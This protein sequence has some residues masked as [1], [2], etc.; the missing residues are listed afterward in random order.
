MVLY[1][2]QYRDVFPRQFMFL[3]MILQTDRSYSTQTWRQVGHLLSSPHPTLR[4]ALELVKLEVTS[5]V[6]REVDE[7]QVT[8]LTVHDRGF[9]PVLKEKLPTPSKIALISV[10]RSAYFVKVIH[11]LPV[12]DLCLIFIFALTPVQRS[13]RCWCE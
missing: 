1:L 4:M 10:A 11:R 3:D 2:A 6:N 12:D 8:D 13:V 7:D 9:L 5:P